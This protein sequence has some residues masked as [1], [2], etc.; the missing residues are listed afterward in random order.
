[1]EGTVFINALFF[2][3]RFKFK[4]T[5]WNT[6]FSLLPAHRRNGELALRYL[7]KQRDS[8]GTV[9]KSSLRLA[10]VSAVAEHSAAARRPCAA[11]CAALRSACHLAL[12]GS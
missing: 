10:V 2:Y 6:L 7:R 12:A 9:Q 8:T 3:A 5:E 4:S 1:M 11:G